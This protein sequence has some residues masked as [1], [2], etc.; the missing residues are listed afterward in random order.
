MQSRSRNPSS[1]KVISTVIFILLSHHIQK[2]SQGNH[3]IPYA[4][5]PVYLQYLEDVET[6][7]NSL[8]KEQSLSDIDDQQKATLQR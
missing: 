1:F 6:R 4:L 8:L 2:S 3:P 7:F 5:S